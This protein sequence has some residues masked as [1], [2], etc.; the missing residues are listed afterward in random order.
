MEGH[1]QR[2]VS[3]SHRAP[4]RH[5]PQRS[6]EEAPSPRRQHPRPRGRPTRPA[7]TAGPSARH[8]DLPPKGA[9][10]GLQ[11]ADAAVRGPV[12]AT[13][14]GVHARTRLLAR[15]LGLAVLHSAHCPKRALHPEAR[16]PGLVCEN[17]ALSGP[18]SPRPTHQ[19]PSST[20]QTSL[21]AGVAKEE[22]TGRR[23][24]CTGQ[25]GERDRHMTQVDRDTDPNSPGPSRECGAGL[26]T[27]GRAR[28]RL[29]QPPRATDPAH[30]QPWD[31][32]VSGAGL[33]RRGLEESVTQSR[34][35]GRVGEEADHRPG[36]G[37]PPPR[38]AG[39]RPRAAGSWRQVWCLV[40]P[41]GQAGRH[42]RRSREGRKGREGTD[43]ETGKTD[44]PTD[45]WR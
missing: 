9:G 7:L 29:S 13:H 34:T 38:R 35:Q 33:A 4:K 25:S 27:A 17:T 42:K 14:G 41:V 22:W 40:L 10:R 8:P 36:S 6:G 39:G 37:E 11:L 44:R 43:A 18:T 32:Y 15:A 5:W 16:G 20:Q 19:A 30:Q 26:P 31:M 28:A 23:A 21:R 12:A 45:S 2:P 24:R 3:A 1:T